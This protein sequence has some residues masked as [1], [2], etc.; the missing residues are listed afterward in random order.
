MREARSCP[1]RGQARGD[2]KR[3]GSRNRTR[4]PADREA[5]RAERAPASCGMV[6]RPSSR[7]RHVHDPHSVRTGR[8]YSSGISRSSISSARPPGL[9]TGDNSAIQ[10]RRSGGSRAT[11][12]L[13]ITIPPLRPSRPTEACTSFAVR[14]V[15]LGPDEKA[16]RDRFDHHRRCSAEWDH[17]LAHVVA[18]AGNRAFAPQ[19]EV[20]S[21]ARSTARGAMRA[22]YR[23]RPA[24]HPR[25][26]SRARMES[27][28]PAGKSPR[29]FPRAGLPGH[30]AAPGHG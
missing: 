22:P 30:G 8:S 17:G 12:S 29:Q 9:S 27:R 19:E 10:R 7:Q 11:S 20:G 28:T 2:G 4:R 15:S 24:W 5:A 13:E 14:R 21:T 1:G 3:R 25:C 23:G 16:V 18:Q 26:R 6:G